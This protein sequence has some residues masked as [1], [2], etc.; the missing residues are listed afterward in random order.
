MTAEDLSNIMKDIEKEIKHYQ[1]NVTHTTNIKKTP[2]KV[3]LEMLDATKPITIIL[4]GGTPTNYTLTQLNGVVTLENG[5]YYIDLNADMF[6]DIMS[7]DI[8]YYD[9]TT[10]ST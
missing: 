6:K 4:N 8:S 7:I 1:E 5:E 2:A 3:K 10:L 9:T